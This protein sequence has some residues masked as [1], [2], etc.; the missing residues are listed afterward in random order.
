MY[1]NTVFQDRIPARRGKIST[2]LEDVFCVFLDFSK[3]RKPPFSPLERSF[4]YPENENKLVHSQ[5]LVRTNPL[6]T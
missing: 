4:R 5:K 1:C 3:E 2:I 6:L